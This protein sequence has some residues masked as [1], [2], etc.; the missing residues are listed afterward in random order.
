ML[1]LIKQ[2]YNLLYKNYDFQ[3]CIVAEDVLLINAKNIKEG[4]KLKQCTNLK[5]TFY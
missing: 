4:T 3:K 1:V 5:Y 2:V